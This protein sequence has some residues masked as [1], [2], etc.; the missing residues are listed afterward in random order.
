MV[1]VAH[2]DTYMYMYIYMYSSYA[3]KYCTPPAQSNYM[4]QVTKICLMY[5]VYMCVNCELA[6]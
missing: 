1:H 5:M 2:Y 3:H 4:H 6:S